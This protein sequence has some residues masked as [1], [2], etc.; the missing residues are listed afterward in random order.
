MNT[1]P[2]VL[3][4]VCSNHANAIVKHCNNG[5]NVQ[6]QKALTLITLLTSLMLQVRIV[7]RLWRFEN[8][9]TRRNS[10]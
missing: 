2:E 5:L 4:K 7:S 9:A 6:N 8:S 10:M 3:K 1:R